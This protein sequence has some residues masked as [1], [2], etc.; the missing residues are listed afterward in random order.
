MAEEHAA[1]AELQDAEG[2]DVE[3]DCPSRLILGILFWGKEYQ[4]TAGETVA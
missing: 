4:E 3:E 1:G 2:G